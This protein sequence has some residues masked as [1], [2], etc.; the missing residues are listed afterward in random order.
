MKATIR[1][2]AAALLLSVIM[3][4]ATPVA[5]AQTEPAA[6]VKVS[7]NTA[8]V[9]QLDTLP[10]VGPATAQRIVD[11]RGKNGPFKRL[12]D[13]MAVQGIGEKKFLRL[14]DGITL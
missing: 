9:E 13:L 7:I 2:L 6:P 1:Y 14:K 10:G 3:A 4:A 8:N 12:E 11:F 5:Q